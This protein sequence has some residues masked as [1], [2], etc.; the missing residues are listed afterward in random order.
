MKFSLEVTSRQKLEGTYITFI[1][2][3]KREQEEKVEKLVKHTRNEGKLINLLYCLINFIP[4]LGV[5]L[6]FTFLW[7]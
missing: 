3:Y 7:A 2:D 6:F 4:A 1:H 5:S